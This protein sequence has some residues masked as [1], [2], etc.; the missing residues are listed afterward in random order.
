MKKTLSR[1]RLS[2]KEKSF[3]VFLSRNEGRITNKKLI[4]LFGV[5]ESTIKRWLARLSEKKLIKFAFNANKDNISRRILITNK[6]FTLISTLVKNSPKIV[7]NFYKKSVYIAGSIFQKST[8]WVIF[9]LENVQSH[10]LKKLSTDQLSD[11]LDMAR[12][13]YSSFLILNLKS[14]IKYYKEG[15]ERAGA[16]DPHLVQNKIEEDSMDE[17]K[18]LTRI[19]DHELK[20][21]RITQKQFEKFVAENGTLVSELLIKRFDAYS[22]KR[23]EVFKTYEGRHYEVLCAWREHDK[24][25]AGENSLS[26]RPENRIYLSEQYRRTEVINRLQNKALELKHNDF[27]SQEIRVGYNKL[28]ESNYLTFE[29]RKTNHWFTI[30]FEDKDFYNKLEMHLSRIGVS[31]PVRSY[32]YNPLKMALAS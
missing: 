4:K 26:R 25:G 23:P 21:I 31:E 29:D 14:I 18:Y 30:D 28:K 27:S 22:A 2:E 9:S 17:T 1:T 19:R 7:T 24:K 20:N 12:T 5:S 32:I 13:R 16:R 8:P 6:G 11:M 15:K 3:F 10:A